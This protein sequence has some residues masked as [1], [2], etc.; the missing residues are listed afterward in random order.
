MTTFPNHHAVHDLRR[1]AGAHRAGT[2]ACCPLPFSR[3]RTIRGNQVFVRPLQQTR[4]PGAE[5]TMPRK[6]D[7][8]DTPGDLQD[9]AHLQVR[10]CGNR[11]TERT[12]PRGPRAKTWGCGSRPVR[13]AASVTA[14]RWPMGEVGVIMPLTTGRMP[15]LSCRWI[16]DQMSGAVT[17]AVC[18]LSCCRSCGGRCPQA[19][20]GRRPSRSPRSSRTADRETL[21]QHAVTGCLRA[22]DW[23]HVLAGRQACR[24]RA[25]PAATDGLRGLRSRC[26]RPQAWYQALRTP[27]IPGA[28]PWP[29]F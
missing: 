8:R 1:R 20:P 17:R 23:R 13:R 21:Q 22:A 16:G 11:S 6:H 14:S 7:T 26:S 4:A 19:C 29:I 2:P 27:S 12:D 9:R 5:H 24:R 18:G 15:W 3:T 28:G 25:R 10:P